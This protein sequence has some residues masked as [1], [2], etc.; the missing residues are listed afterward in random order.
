MEE[1]HLPI[2]RKT[3]MDWYCGRLIVLKSRP[4]TKRPSK[5]T[6]LKAKGI[7]RSYLTFI[8]IHWWNPLAVGQMTRCQK[9]RTRRHNA[10]SP[11]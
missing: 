1:S 11:L 9:G 2:K 5:H 7:I 10:A 8:F 3:K 4:L 6:R